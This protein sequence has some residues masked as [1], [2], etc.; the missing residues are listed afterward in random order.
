MYLTKETVSQRYLGYTNKRTAKQDMRTLS[1]FLASCQFSQ[2]MLYI[3]SIAVYYLVSGFSK[4]TD[5]VDSE[6]VY[7][8]AGIQTLK[9][10]RLSST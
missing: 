8:C 2:H 7:I 10:I 1:R 4:I 5:Q 6:D 3:F 9:H